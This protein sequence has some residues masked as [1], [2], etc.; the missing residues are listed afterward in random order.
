M[1]LVNPQG[2]QGVP[3]QEAPAPVMTDAAKEAKKAA[4][5][6][7]IE[8]MKQERQKEHERYL[9]IRD[10]LQQTGGFKGMAK[11]D[12]DFIL[13]K[14]V[15]PSE[16]AGH[17]GPSF[18]TQVF[19]DKPAVGQ[20][21]S[22]KDIITKTYKGMDTINASIKKWAAKGVVVEAKLNQADMLATTYTIKELP[23]A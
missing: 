16:R 18:F 1:A 7:H 23:A 2:T 20:S 8:K 17:S 10:F 12:Q 14:C 3:A 15:P 11:E 4:A 9:S 21:V 5:K 22:L 13:A 6:R 19:G